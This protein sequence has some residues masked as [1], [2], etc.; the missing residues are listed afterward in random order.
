MKEKFKTKQPSVKDPRVSTNRTICEVHREMYE[1]FLN[2][3]SLPDSFANKMIDLIEE[4]YIMAK[5]MNA[6][7]SQYKHNWDDSFWEKQRAEIVKEKLER[8]KNRGKS[9]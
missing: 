1:V 3:K 2:D 8:R 7:L 9:I 4:A 5:K 6:K